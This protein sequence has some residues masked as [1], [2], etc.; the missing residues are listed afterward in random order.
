VPRTAPNTK[1][2]KSLGAR[3]KVVRIAATTATVCD[4]CGRAKPACVP[5]SGLVCPTSG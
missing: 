3:L 1:Y 2:R 5:V 4:A